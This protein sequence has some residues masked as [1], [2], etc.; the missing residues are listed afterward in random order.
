MG[1]GRI[2]TY[3]KTLGISEMIAVKICEPIAQ[4]LSFDVCHLEEHQPGY[5]ILSPYRTIIES[6]SI[7]FFSGK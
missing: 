4:V 7:T 3:Q 1:F 6:L 2:P 5:I